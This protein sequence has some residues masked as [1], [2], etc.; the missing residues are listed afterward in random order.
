MKTNWGALMSHW[1][2]ED[3]NDKARRWILFWLFAVI[4][5]AAS[6]AIIIV[7]LIPNDDPAPTP[8]PIP[9]ITIPNWRNVPLDA[10]GNIVSKSPPCVEVVSRKVFCI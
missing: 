9:S 5:A 4:A 8:A 7:L 3:S 1:E 6:A 10:N 2:M